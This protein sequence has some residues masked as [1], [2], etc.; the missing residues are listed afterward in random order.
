MSTTRLQHCKPNQTHTYIWVLSGPAEDS[1]MFFKKL[2][3]LG[4]KCPVLCIIQLD[5]CIT[6]KN[7]L[8]FMNLLYPFR[9]C[10]CSSAFHE[11][12]EIETSPPLLL[13][14][15]SIFVLNKFNFYAIQ[16]IR[17]IW[18][19]WIVLTIKRSAATFSCAARSHC[20]DT[21]TSHF[22]SL[23]RHRRSTILFP[24]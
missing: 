12:P 4:G 9:L 23:R 7:P 14:V 19:S 17:T 22:L 3:I 10:R 5:V 21:K 2:G 24:H 15:V 6:T 1:Q 18:R 11:E 8:W 13:R 16:V 20:C